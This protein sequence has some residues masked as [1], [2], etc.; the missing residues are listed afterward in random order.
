MDKRKQRWRHGGGEAQQEDAA[1]RPEIETSEPVG[2]KGQW[3]GETEAAPRRAAARCPEV[4]G[5]GWSAS[6]TWEVLWGSGGAEAGGGRAR[7]LAER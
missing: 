5:A 4:G 2:W 7:G 6:T 1:R 3:L